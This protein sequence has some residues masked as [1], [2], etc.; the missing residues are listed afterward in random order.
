MR[1]SLVDSGFLPNEEKVPWC[2]VQSL[3]R[4]GNVAQ[5]VL[6]VMAITEKS[7]K[8]YCVLLQIF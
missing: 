4:L 7:Q 2:P 8:T 5:T 3:E 1:Q 6:Y